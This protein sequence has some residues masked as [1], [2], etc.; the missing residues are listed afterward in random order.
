[1]AFD[2]F[3]ISSLSN[4]QVA[5]E[6]IQNW[7]YESIDPQAEV[8]SLNYFADMAQSLKVNDR[9]V[10][11]EMTSDRKVAV[12][13]YALT[14]RVNEQA[15]GTNEN[16]IVALFDGV[17]QVATE[18]TFD[19]VSATATQMVVYPASST[20]KSAY[21][22]FLGT[23]DGTT[24]TLAIAV[25]TTVSGSAVTVYSGTYTAPIGYGQVLPLTAGTATAATTFT[26]TITPSSVPAG[27]GML[28]LFL[29]SE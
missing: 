18:L 13:R 4:Q 26:L 11:I 7:Q 10:V 24:A 6:R 19:N 3:Y 5:G 23:V 2:R 12:R 29:I 20:I 15:D 16:A 17:D 27:S 1:M 28:K 8:T 21:G 22:V 14:V 9:I 25:K